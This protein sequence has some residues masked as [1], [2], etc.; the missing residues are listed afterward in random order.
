M[1]DAGGDPH[2]HGDVHRADAIGW[3]DGHREVADLLI[4]RG[5]RHHIFSAILLGDSELIRRVVDEN[6]QALH[7]RLSRFEEG[8]TTLHFAISRKRYDLLGHLMMLRDRTRA[9]VLNSRA[10]KAV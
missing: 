9:N 5:A 8:Y 10:G 7:R 3:A 4:E 2:G 6:P 1:L